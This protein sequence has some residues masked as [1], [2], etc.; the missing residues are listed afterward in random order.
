MCCACNWKNVGNEDWQLP[1]WSSLKSIIFTTSKTCVVTMLALAAGAACDEWLRNNDRTTTWQTTQW[2]WQAW[3]D[4]A[5]RMKRQQWRWTLVMPVAE[6]IHTMTQTWWIDET[7]YHSQKHIE[8]IMNLHN[9]MIRYECK[10]FQPYYWR[11]K[12]TMNDSLIPKKMQKSA[13]HVPKNK[14]EISWN[15][16]NKWKTFIKL[17]RFPWFRCMHWPQYTKQKQKLKKLT[18]K[19]SEITS[20]H[21]GLMNDTSWPWVRV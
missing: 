20:S 13:D 1:P 10:C 4:C 11:K 15:L 14:S 18:G 16:M 12:E 21:A 6:E 19:D 5:D 9:M 7:K 8:T 17:Q 2:R 3:S